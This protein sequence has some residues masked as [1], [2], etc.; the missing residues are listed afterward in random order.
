MK[1]KI[2]SSL[3]SIAILSCSTTIH[4]NENKIDAINKNVPIQVTRIDGS[5]RYETSIK[6]K[7][8]LDI[9]NKAK[10][11]VIASGE[12]FADALS[13]GLLASEYNCSL[14][15]IKNNSSNDHLKDKSIFQNMDKIFV[16]GG[17]STISDKTIQ[18]LG[19]KNVKRLSGK[20]RFETS[21]KVDDEI[22]N[23][24][25]IK[26]PDRGIYTDVIAVY[27]GYN[28]PDALAAVPF[29]YM[30]NS[31]PN[32]NYLSFY[33][34][35]VSPEGRKTGAVTLVFGGKSSVPEYG[36]EETRFA[37][38]NRYETATLIAN[39]YKN[40]LGID[41]N[42]VILISG[43]NYADALSSTPI[44]SMEN[45]AILLSG[46]KKLNSYAKE[47]I[48]KN[49]IKD[50]IIVGGENSISNDVIKE[51]KDIR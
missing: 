17:T 21:Y 31:R 24:I 51:L 33:P 32:T 34:D 27:D 42:K 48:L 35:N 30:Y 49:N 23:L 36:Y 26:N 41:I 45:A 11:I 46:S 37:G 13:G 14:V 12:S 10:N 39:G 29:M 18:E 38:K 8:H 47:F 43:E 2:I 40:I 19:T 5:N 7:E 44:A 4:A 3:L 50:V 20:T 15:L 9:T 25:K 6:T 28:F 1:K 16:I 22:Q